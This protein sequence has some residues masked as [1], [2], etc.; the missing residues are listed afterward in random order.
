MRL[1]KE[2]EIGG[3]VGEDKRLTE[4]RMGVVK[5]VRSTL[6]GRVE[7]AGVGMYY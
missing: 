5:H 4:G 7:G 1:E 2:G 6:C 3:R